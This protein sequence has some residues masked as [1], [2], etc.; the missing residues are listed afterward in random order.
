[1]FIMPAAPNGCQRFFTVDTCAMMRLTSA[2]QSML[3][4]VSSQEVTISVCEKF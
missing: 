4:D 1:M 3:N 2:V